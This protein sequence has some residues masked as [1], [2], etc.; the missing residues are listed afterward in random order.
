MA[1]AGARVA[2]A[3]AQAVT[4]AAPPAAIAAVVAAD[5]EQVQE[6]Y[7][8]TC[9]RPLFGH[10]AAAERLCRPPWR[11]CPLLPPLCAV[12]TKTP[13]MRTSSALLL[14]AL[15]AESCAARLSAKGHACVQEDGT[16]PFNAG[17]E[18]S[19]GLSYGYGLCRRDF[20]QAGVVQAR[21]SLSNLHAR[22]P[23]SHF[24]HPDS[25]LISLRLFPRLYIVQNRAPSRLF[26]TPVVLRG[27]SFHTPAKPH[28]HTTKCC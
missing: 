26:E 25:S 1:M 13:C 4:A 15:W 24:D 12:S 18:Q 5:G 2:D 28:T 9:C 20:H 19:L 8:A 16:S 14:S 17:V 7:S 10:A 11:R 6:S 22:P 23:P 27:V 21:M 3:G